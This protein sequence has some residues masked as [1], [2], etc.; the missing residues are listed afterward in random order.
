MVPIINCLTSIYAGFVVFSTLGYMAKVKRTTVD[1]V[2]Q[3]GGS[4]W[5]TSGKMLD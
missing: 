2:T 5:P 4:W 1:K 3:G